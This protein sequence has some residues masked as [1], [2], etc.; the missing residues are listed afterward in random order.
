[1]NLEQQESQFPEESERHHHR[2]SEMEPVEDKT[3][4]L[5][6]VLSMQNDKLI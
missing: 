6:S 4:S 2:N 5:I 1:M 3:V